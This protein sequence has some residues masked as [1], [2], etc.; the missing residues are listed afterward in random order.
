MISDNKE[1]KIC[2]KCGRELPL[3]K[4]KS[5]HDYIWCI[6]KECYNKGMREKRHQQRLSDELETYHK[7]KSMKIQ[8]QLWQDNSEVG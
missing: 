1:T 5:S 4:F 7:D 2:K 6:C 8:R 3:D